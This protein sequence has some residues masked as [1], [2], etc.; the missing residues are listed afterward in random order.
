VIAVEAESDIVEA[1]RTRG[2]HA[3]GAS[4]DEIR[5]HDPVE[6]WLFISHCVFQATH[7]M[8]FK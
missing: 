1:S 4:L 7:R 8:A 3:K 2:I 5:H 6:H